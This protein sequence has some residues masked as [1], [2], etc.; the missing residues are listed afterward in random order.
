MSINSTAEFEDDD[1]DKGAIIDN[2]KEKDDDVVVEGDTGA[3]D[4]VIEEDDDRPA[5]QRARAD[6]ENLTDEQRRERRRDERKLQKQRRRD[7]IARLNT[8]NAG[9][10]D[11]LAQTNVRLQKLEEG[12]GT[13]YTRQV[14][15]AF[16][17]ANKRAEVLKGKIKEATDAG[18]GAAVAALT[19]ELI[20]VKAD[21]RQIEGH[22]AELARGGRKQATEDDDT[23]RGNARETEQIDPEVRR[24]L[25][26]TIAQNVKVFTGK[27][28][29]YVLS[30]D[31][32]ED[33][34][35]DDVRDSNL[36]RRIDEELTA[37]GSNPSTADHWIELEARLK[38]ELPH[39][40][41]ARRKDTRQMAD[42]DS[43]TTRERPNNGRRA[44]P[45]MNGSGRNG[46]RGGDAGTF[47]LSK[48]RVEAMKESGAWDDSVRKK[49]QIDAFKA[50]DR[51]NPSK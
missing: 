32:A 14:E 44:A 27:H 33:A 20:D 47:V 13:D 48:Q 38:E 42:D 2:S 50:Y 21:I 17:G 41:V 34:S 43:T 15:A 49:R 51:A 9:L 26:R 45:P 40:A 36:V 5:R 16:N 12:R 23:R 10:K 28:P 6:E 24:E 4:V 18:D 37:E 31:D 39:R 11:A 30:D 1:E 19:D 3:D 46:G 29:W 7:Y 22:K 25:Q 8:E 35:D